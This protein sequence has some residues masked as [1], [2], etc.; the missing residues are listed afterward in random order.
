VAITLHL[1]NTSRRTNRRPFS[2]RPRLFSLLNEYSSTR[3]AN[4]QVMALLHFYA[5]NLEGAPS[6]EQSCRDVFKASRAA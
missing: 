1:R 4:M 5:D 3:R 2:L 6:C